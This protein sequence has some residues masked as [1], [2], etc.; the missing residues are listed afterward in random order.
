M[1]DPTSSDPPRDKTKYH[2]HELRHGITHTFP[3]GGVPEMTVLLG[4]LSTL[5]G[6]EVHLSLVYP[7]LEDRKPPTMK[8]RFVTKEQF[9]KI[10]QCGPDAPA[11]PAGFSQ[12][13][14]VPAE[15]HEGRDEVVLDDEAPGQMAESWRRRLGIG[16]EEPMPE[17]VAVGQRVL[18]FVADEREGVYVVEVDCGEQPR[19]PYE[20]AP[21][22]RYVDHVFL[23]NRAPSKF[24]HPE[25]E[26]LGELLRDAVN[27]STK[28]GYIWFV[29]PIFVAEQM[30]NVQLDQ[31][32]KK[33]IAYCEDLPDDLPAPDD[34]LIGLIYGRRLAGMQRICL[35]LDADADDCVQTESMAVQVDDPVE[36]AR[37][38]KEIR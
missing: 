10:I 8:L 34:Q 16:P 36:L 22:E 17:A 37:L 33:E 15:E 1:P 18:S 26:D 6:R 3:D 35:D 5:P 25:V 31:E 27:L 11:V 4:P 30:L 9:P 20:G 2:A 28:H 7:H 21:L 23:Y 24:P 13:P 32:T 12:W 29:H 38:F 19:G 14:L